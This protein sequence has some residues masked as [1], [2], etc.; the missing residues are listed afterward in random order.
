[1]AHCHARLLSREKSWS[2]A[3]ILTTNLASFP[4]VKGVMETLCEKDSPSCPYSVC[5]HR[6]HHSR[7]SVVMH[8]GTQWVTVRHRCLSETPP[9]WGGKHALDV[10]PQAL[11]SENLLKIKIDLR[12]T[13]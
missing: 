6:C 10:A 7:A 1:M 12:N 9:D 11:K 2:V 3:K 13:D 8:I 4:R 5:S